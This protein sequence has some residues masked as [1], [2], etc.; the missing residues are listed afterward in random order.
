[1]DDDDVGGFRLRHDASPPPG[2]DSAA[3]GRNVRG[4]MEQ[5]HLLPDAT[6]EQG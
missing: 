3:A 1:M 6:P 5:F 4:E 2:L